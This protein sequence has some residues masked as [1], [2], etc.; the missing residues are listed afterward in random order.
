LTTKQSGRS[1]CFSSATR[2]IYGLCGNREL[3]LVK[4]SS[5]STEPYASSDL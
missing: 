5:N 4:E 3:T 1:R 2:A